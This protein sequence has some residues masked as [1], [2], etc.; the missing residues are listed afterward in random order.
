[1]RESGYDWIR[2]KNRVTTN[3]PPDGTWQ[4]WEVAFFRDR[5]DGKGV[6]L[7]IGTEVDIIDGESQIEVGPKI[8]REEGL[9]YA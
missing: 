7:L 2:Q 5:P 8:L 9:L 6:W 1:M 3:D 4:D